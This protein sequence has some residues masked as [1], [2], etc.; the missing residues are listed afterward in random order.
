VRPLT[1]SH[2]TKET[3]LN[4]KL[5]RLILLGLL[6]S[7]GILNAQTDFKPGYIIKTIGDTILGQ[8]D[9]RGDLLMGRL[10]KFKDANNTIK[11]Y[12][13]DD[14]VAFRFYGSKFYVS[15][16]INNKKLFLEYLVNGELNIYYR[17]DEIGDHYY[18][19][20]EGVRL[21][22]IPYEE[23]IKDVGD[24][25][26]FYESQKHIGILNYY[27]QDAPVLKSRI[28]SIKKPKHQNLIKLA[29]DYHNVICKGEKCIIYEKKSPLFRVLPEIVGGVIKYSSNRNFYDKFYPNAG[30]IGHVWMPRSNEKL[31]FRT[32][33]LVSELDFGD[34]KRFFYKIPCQLE[35]IYFKGIFRPR[36]AYG[37]NLYLPNY[38]SVSF[39]L[40]GN[41][42]LSK[43]FFLS[44]TS[45]IE[46]DSM[47]LILPKE[48]LSY[49]L[50][51]GLF[52]SI[53]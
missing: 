51:M 16:E 22:E 7:A 1:V 8:I 35:Y 26:V 3:I 41:I 45:D 9:S 4:M 32:G 43:S 25:Q 24:K 13:P 23:G 46:F 20:K 30:L 36:L 33:V 44:V 17:R 2:Y 34:E 18:L 11:E 38:Q 48:I 10:C 5:K 19:D 50:H 14:I 31:Y 6:I 27:M 53:K 28:Q 49:S 21:T 52:M 15:K 39:N 40:G 12:S 47:V 42:K 29:E 37:L